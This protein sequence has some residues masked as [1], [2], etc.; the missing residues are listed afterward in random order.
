MQLLQAQFFSPFS[1]T[2]LQPSC[3]HVLDQLFQAEIANKSKDGWHR[4]SQ[5][6]HAPLAKRGPQSPFRKQDLI[7]SITAYKEILIAQMNSF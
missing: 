3:Q 2:K 4:L 7:F 1:L 5:R 6:E